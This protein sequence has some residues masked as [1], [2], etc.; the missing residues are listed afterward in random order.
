[1]AAAAGRRAA[2]RR[3]AG[4]RAALPMRPM[5]LDIQVAGSVK[6]QHI[7][8]LVTAG[9]TA[10]AFGGGIYR[11]PDMAGEVVEM[12]KLAEEQTK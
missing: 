9:T 8:D 10:I 3:A 11:A 5:P 2:G 1:M 6:R 12:R 7:P 4:R